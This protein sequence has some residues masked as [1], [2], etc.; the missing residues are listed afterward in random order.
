[1]NKYQEEREQSFTDID[2]EDREALDRQYAMNQVFK[3]LDISRETL[4][5]YEK[6]GL[7]EPKRGENSYRSFDSYDMYRLLMIDFYKKRGFRT[8]QMQDIMSVK[9]MQN[10]RSQFVQKREEILEEQRRC[11]QMLNLLDED[12]NLLDDLSR[13]T[14]QLSIRGFPLYRKVDEISYMSEFTA[15]REHLM[16]HPEVTSR[17]VF[18]AMVREVQ[19]D[20]QKGYQNSTVHI[21]EKA[22]SWKA[23]EVY[24]DTGPCVY[25]VVKSQGDDEVMKQMYE[26]VNEYL[27]KHG[28]TMKGKVYIVS[29]LLLIN[30]KIG[31][32]GYSEAY[33]PIVE[34]NLK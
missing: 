11:Q 27:I 1:M 32:I 33:I 9:S 30:E 23:D 28:L 14:F 16:K 12:L 7:I 24:L 29:R 31:N 26:L 19:V 25:A 13:H 2:Q 10:M 6:L 5:Y 17:D 22:E 8:S 4:R 18:S 15:Y 21:V 34:A 3:T 20:A